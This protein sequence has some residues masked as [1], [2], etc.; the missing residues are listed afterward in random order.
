MVCIMCECVSVCGIVVRDKERYNYVIHDGL[1]Y[2]IGREYRT[3]VYLIND[4]VK[5]FQFDQ[6]FFANYN[7]VTINML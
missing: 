4:L 7:Q 5:F 6:Y 2:I 1:G 3:Q